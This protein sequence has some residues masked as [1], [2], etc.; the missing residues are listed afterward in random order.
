MPVPRLFRGRLRM[1]ERPSISGRIGSKLILSL[2][3]AIS[4]VFVGVF[5]TFIYAVSLL[6]DKQNDLA[7]LMYELNGD[8]RQN[9]LTLQQSYLT[10][11]DFLEVD[12]VAAV[13]KWAQDNYQPAVTDHRGRDAIVGRYT[14]RR[15]RRDLQKKGFVQV[16]DKDGGIAVSFG[17]FENGEY[18]DAV[19][20]LS[21]TGADP[22][23]VK[24][25]L[26]KVIADNSGADAIERRI[27]ALND[28]I[29]DETLAADEKRIA[30]L[31]AVDNIEAKKAE[32]ED[33]IREIVLGVIVL[34]VIGV[35]L[36]AVTLHLVSRRV[37]TSPLRTISKVMTRIVQRETP[38][39]P[40]LKRKDEIGALARGLDECRN[41]MAENEAFQEQ[42]ARE[43]AAQRKR[44]EMT[45][46]R[47][48]E[49]N[50]N[51]GA[52]AQAVAEAARDMQGVAETTTSTAREIGEQVGA[53]SSASDE[54][55]SHVET[56]ST[57][58]EQLRASIEEISER[59]GNAA[60]MAREAVDRANDTDRT[61]GQLSEMAHDVDRIVEIIDE[62]ANQTNLLALNATIEAARAGE[63]GK[64]FAVVASEVKALA[65]QTAKATGDISARIQ[66][67]RKVTGDS[68]TA[69]Q[70]IGD[71]I[72]RIDGI[73][74]ST[75]SVVEQERTTLQSIF[76]SMELTGQVTHTVARQIQGVGDASARNDTVAQRVLDASMALSG[77]AEMLHTQVEKFIG[78]IR[79]AEA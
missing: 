17:L 40:Y 33:F 65:T 3:L 46:A 34:G 38:D 74:S 36:T 14:K 72:G 31:S 16:E 63:A 1:P 9:M 39:V 59:A 58:V 24:Q 57:A 6:T 37:V 7:Q 29:A 13:S 69:I 53:V 49:F 5:A 48:D 51:A 8:L 26:E 50:R 10:V 62:I 70:S 15:M 68:V 21:I 64:G 75:V 4:L 79:L 45:G 76:R 42:Q 23:E 61:V 2:T 41:V 66:A 56:A 25:G 43:A 30:I 78:D 73:T 32:V 22:Q 47:I 20:E 19:R 67:M 35:L 71:V 27:A 52:I 55:R 77:Q 44:A 11:P 12:P 18:Q 60:T 54:A 28:R